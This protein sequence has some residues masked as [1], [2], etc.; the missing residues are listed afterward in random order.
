M[1]TFCFNDKPQ[2]CR[3]QE[4]SDLHNTEVKPSSDDNCDDKHENKCEEVSVD[5]SCVSEEMSEK[6]QHPLVSSSVEDFLPDSPL[7]SSSESQQSLIE[8][9][10]KSDADKNAQEMVT[11]TTLLTPTTLPEAETVSN[12]DND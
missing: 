7:S 8:I 5:K 4:N 3:P 10:Q 2:E 1:P 12:N 6:V 9:D 11:T